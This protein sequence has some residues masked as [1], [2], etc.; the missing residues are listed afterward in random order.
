[1]CQGS[2]GS[3][4]SPVTLLLAHGTAMEPSTALGHY[5]TRPHRAGAQVP[6]DSE[7]IAFL[8]IFI[9]TRDACPTSSDQSLI[10]YSSQLQ[11]GM[12]MYISE[13]R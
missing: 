8:K 7:K 2:G 1:M 4:S 5:C 6:K 9:T 10:C 11:P 13:S 3:E 12:Y